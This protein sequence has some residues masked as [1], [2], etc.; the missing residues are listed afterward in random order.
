MGITIQKNVPVPTFRVSWPFAEMKVG[1]SILV[2]DP[3]LTPRVRMAAYDFGKRN[4]RRFMT[5][6]VEGGVRVW[7]TK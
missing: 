2:E 4:S 3:G 7:R 1:D 6:S 5:R